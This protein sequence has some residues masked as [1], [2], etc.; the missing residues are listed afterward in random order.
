MDE[1][2]YE[3]IGRV[4]S[5]ISRCVDDSGGGVDLLMG[6][7]HHCIHHHLDCD[8]KLSSIAVK[9]D[10][11]WAISD[12]G[13]LVV[14][15]GYTKNRR[16]GEDWVELRTDGPSS[17]LS[18]SLF[19]ESAFVLDNSYSLW[20]A[21]CV[22]EHNPFGKNFYR[23]GSPLDGI[24]C[25][26]LTSNPLLAVSKKGIF[27]SVDKTIDLFFISTLRTSLYFAAFVVPFFYR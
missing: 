13:K 12:E 4:V 1:D 26:S 9:D 17:L 23:I 27:I 18:I 5:V 7:P 3:D 2:E 16:F 21:D 14:R 6:L 10:A 24:S 8:W 22:N 25:E 11:V 19:N 15:V 20:R